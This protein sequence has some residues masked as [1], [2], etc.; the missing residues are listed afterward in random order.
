MTY[1]RQY[2]CRNFF[3][4][5]C[6]LFFF[7]NKQLKLKKIS[8]RSKKPLNL[9]YFNQ[10][11]SN[12]LVFNN[13]ELFYDL[14]LFKVLLNIPENTNTYK[15]NDLDLNKF[16]NI[17]NKNIIYSN[18][19]KYFKHLFNNNKIISKIQFHFFFF[20]KFFKH[21]VIL[22]APFRDKISKNLLTNQQ[23]YVYLVLTFKL[24][25]Y[26]KFN[27][28]IIFYIFLITFINTNFCSSNILFLHSK[29]I[30]LSFTLVNYSDIIKN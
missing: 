24:K 25:S 23:F 15:T 12:N 2:F 8:F 20:T 26:L 14:K 29:K 10:I 1:K 21:F 17:L 11:N 4:L 28:K 7:F 6:F 13:K 19:K 30:Q 5:I 3:L 27:T 22:R 9:I 16:K 18:Y